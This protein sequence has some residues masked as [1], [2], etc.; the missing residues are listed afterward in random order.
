MDFN[1]KRNNM[2]LEGKKIAILATDGFEKSELF[3]PLETLKNEGAT[4]HII[5]NKDG[6]IKSWDDTNWGKTINVDKTLNQAN[7]SD[8]NALVL[9]GGQINPDVLRIEDSALNFVKAFFKSGKPVAAICHAPWLLISAGVINGRKVTS[10]KSIK[11]DVI[12]A[13]GNWVDEEVVVDS[14]LITSRNPKDLPAFCNKIIEE[15]R[16]G[17]HE[18]QH[19]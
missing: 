19:A 12:N 1:K 2:K 14:G 3:Q 18:A 7:E 11:D 16:E 5:S 13:G 15:V 9:P 17:K 4:V 6:A 10:Y 8:Y